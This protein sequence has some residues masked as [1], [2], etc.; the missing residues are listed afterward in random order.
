MLINSVREAQEVLHNVVDKMQ[1]GWD[2]NQAIDALNY[3]KE[4][5][6]AVESIEYKQEG[7]DL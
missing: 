1:D 4:F 3:L 7:M 5:T 2:K 6:T